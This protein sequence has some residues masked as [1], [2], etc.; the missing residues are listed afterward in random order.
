[1]LQYLLH[2]GLVV[3]KEPGAAAIDRAD[4]HNEHLLVGGLAGVG[5]ADKGRLADGAWDG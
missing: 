3:D 1:M 2:V 5:Q 4:P